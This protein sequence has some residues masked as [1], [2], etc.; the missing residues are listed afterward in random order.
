MV[1]LGP[2]APVVVAGDSV[3]FTEAPLVAL[4]VVTGILVV[5]DT[6]GSGV[7]VVIGAEVVVADDRVVDA[8]DR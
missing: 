1:E 6:G 8:I 4:V 5:V 7:L 2:A 3:V